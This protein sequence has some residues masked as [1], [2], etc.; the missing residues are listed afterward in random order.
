MKETFVTCWICMRNKFWSTFDLYKSMSHSLI[1]CL[2]SNLVHFEKLILVH[3]WFSMQPWVRKWTKIY[4]SI[5]WKWTKSDFEHV[6]GEWLIDLYKSTVDQN[7]FRMHIQPVKHVSFT[8]FT[9]PN[10]YIYVPPLIINFG[11]WFDHNSWKAN[12]RKITIR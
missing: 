6:I 4:F 1:T 10:L 9:G 11:N 5:L 3:F 7:L 8:H 12:T 2:K